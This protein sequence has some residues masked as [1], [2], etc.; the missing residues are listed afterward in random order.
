MYTNINEFINEIYE[1]TFRNKDHSSGIY[2]ESMYVNQLHLL[3]END[4][5]D[6]QHKSQKYLL[7]SLGILDAKW[8]A[9]NL[10]LSAIDSS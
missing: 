2:K 1:N 9:L 7:F 8:F 4:K 6:L 10:A 3:N 5:K